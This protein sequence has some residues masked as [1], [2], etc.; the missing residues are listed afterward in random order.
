MAVADYFTGTGRITIKKS[1]SALGKTA[2]A[3]ADNRPQQN[4][5]GP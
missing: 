1:L 3:V 2:A 5:K 4:L